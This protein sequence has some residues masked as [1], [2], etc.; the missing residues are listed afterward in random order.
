MPIDYGVF[1]D[2][3]FKTSRK[4]SSQLKFDSYGRP[5]KE[6]PKRKT[7]NKDLREKVWLRYMKNKTEGKCYCCRI[8]PIHFTDFEVGHNI[9]KANGGSDNILNLRPICRS[10][11]R[12]MGTKSIEWYR[13]KYY[14]TPK[15]TSK[16]KAVKKKATKK[17]TTSKK[18]VTKRDPFEI[19][20]INLWR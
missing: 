7:I 11:N 5:I 6:K 10:C 2:N 13:N 17:K 3:P 20:K 1:G 14:S 19:P 4:K 8:K 9:S 18:K 16:K 12:G 15:E